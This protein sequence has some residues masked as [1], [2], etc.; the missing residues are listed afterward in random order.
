MIRVLELSHFMVKI[1]FKFSRFRMFMLVVIG[2]VRASPKIRP[3]LRVRLV[4]QEVVR[5]VR[6][7]Q[8]I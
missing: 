6:A 2:I 1:R 4:W 5:V 7:S 3:M 8:V